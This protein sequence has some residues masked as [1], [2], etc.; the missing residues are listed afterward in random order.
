MAVPFELSE[1]VAEKVVKR[2]MTPLREA[3]EK[4][5]GAKTKK[6]VSFTLEEIKLLDTDLGMLGMALA[7]RFSKEKD[8]QQ[9]VRVVAEENE[10]LHITVDTLSEHLTDEK[11]YTTYLEEK[12][13]EI[14]DEKSKETLEVPSVPV[15]A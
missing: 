7:T 11:K 10:R 2:A 8:L 5:Q 13:K 3:L 14:V 15:E 1:E 4:H 9:A 6:K 12:I